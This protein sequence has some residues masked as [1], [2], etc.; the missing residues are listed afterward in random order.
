MP[1]G[2]INRGCGWEAEGG[3]TEAKGGG[4]KLE[5]KGVSQIDCRREKEV[6]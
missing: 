1:K 5:Q 3:K 2:R 6:R 4:K